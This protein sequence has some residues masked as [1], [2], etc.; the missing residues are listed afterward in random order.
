MGSCD[1][2]PRGDLAE[3]ISLAIGAAASSHTP[4]W[5]M[6]LPPSDGF[7]R[8]ETADA[9][10]KRDPGA[11]AERICV[12]LA[13]AMARHPDVRA[14]SAEVYASS[15][16][17]QLWTSTGLHLSH[18][19]TSLEVDLA[20]EPLPGP[21]DQEVHETFADVSL[22]GLDVHRRV[23]E[24]AQQA[25]CL[26]HTEVPG[27]SAD[28]PVLLRSADLA[29]IL[30]ALRSSAT[31]Y[32]QYRKASVLALGAS[33]VKGERRGEALNL[34]VDPAIPAMVQSHRGTRDGVVARGGALIVDSVLEALVVDPQYGHY[35]GLQPN[36]L[37]G[38][39]VVPS[40]NTPLHELRAPG[41][42]EV[43]RFLSLMVDPMR[44]TWSGEIKLATLHTADGPV[45]LKGG[46]IS[47]DVRENLAD[48]VF[49]AETEKVNRPGSKTELPLGYTGPAALLR[50][51]VRIAGT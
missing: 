20:V 13:R 39:L 37:G 27:S 51:G 35:L 34:F 45:W 49:S 14:C 30:D 48:I 19:R 16:I 21:N 5:P 2:D 41:T 31:A 17:S 10:L 9:E 50:S 47:G 4:S 7:P 6:A 28:T 26:G 24:A 44:L 8:V 11:A 38:N 43:H 18:D 46:V 42:I 40:G 1:V 15:W 12:E 33:V 36:G 32:R 25:R 22:V 3:Q 23:D 29:E